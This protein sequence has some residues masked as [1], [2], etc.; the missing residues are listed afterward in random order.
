M[1]LFG[2]EGTLRL[3]GDKLYGGRRG[4]AALQEIV[5]PSDEEGRWQVEEEFINAIRGDGAI[6]LTT[7]E[8]GVRYMEFS[9]AVAR[10]MMEGIAVSLPLQI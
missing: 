6:A 10:S 5:I 9:E 7:F 3:S 4:D 1:Y 8:D 2:S